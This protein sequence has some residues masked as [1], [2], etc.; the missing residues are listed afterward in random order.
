M[1]DIPITVN[2]FV[3]SQQLEMVKFLIQRMRTDEAVKLTEKIIKQLDEK[4]EPEVLR[5]IKNQ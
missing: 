4:L 5:S 2:Y 3:F 1:S